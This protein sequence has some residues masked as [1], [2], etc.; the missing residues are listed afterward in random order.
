[1]S[2]SGETRI[3]L[4]EF[5]RHFVL[6]HMK[7][8]AAAVFDEVKERAQRS[9]KSFASDLAEWITSQYSQ[10]A[11]QDDNWYAREVPL[12]VCYVA[13]TEFRRHPVPKNQRFVDFL[14]TQRQKVESGTFPCSFE[15]RAPW[16][17]LMPEPL[18][19]EREPDRYYILDGQLRVI[20][21]W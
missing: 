16:S 13:H 21:H 15:I 8:R 14:P 17:G 6:T 5:H 20:R 4:H 9:G 1:M 7:D 10:G 12:D 19:Q 11:Y 3:S 18:A 2:R